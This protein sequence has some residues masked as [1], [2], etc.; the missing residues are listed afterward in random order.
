MENSTRCHSH[1][2]SLGSSIISKSMKGS[3][4]QKSETLW[5]KWSRCALLALMASE[6]TS[7]GQ[8]SPGWEECLYLSS[9]VL[10]WRSVG[11]MYNWLYYGVLGGWSRSMFLPPSASS[12]MNSQPTFPWS[13]GASNRPGP[14]CNPRGAE[15]PCLWVNTEPLSNSAQ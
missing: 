10:R 12:G 13:R 2:C 9:W 8:F 14:H 6:P 11:C 3:W 1:K 15:I 5:T 7:W 4:A